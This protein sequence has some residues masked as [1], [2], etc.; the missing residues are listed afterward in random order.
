[1]YWALGC[2]EALSLRLTMSSDWKQFFAAA[3]LQDFP[4]DVLEKMLKTLNDNCLTPKPASLSIFVRKPKLLESFNWPV[5][6]ADLFEQHALKQLGGQGLIVPQPQ[7]QP[8]PQPLPTSFYPQTPQAPSGKRT[9]VLSSTRQQDPLKIVPVIF[10]CRLI[11]RH[12]HR[13]P[14]VGGWGGLVVDHQ[15]VCRCWTP[16]AKF[17]WTPPTTKSEEAQTSGRLKETPS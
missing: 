11:Q 1:V 17:A 5:G 7:P 4:S 10:F 16:K 6:A 15:H 12:T 9:F 13:Q 8:Q 3:G 14:S 2:F